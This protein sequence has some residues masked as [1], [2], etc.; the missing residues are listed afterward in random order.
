MKELIVFRNIKYLKKKIFSN[1]INEL[2]NLRLK[3]KNDN[4]KDLD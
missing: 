4:R 2:F 3:A 1:Y